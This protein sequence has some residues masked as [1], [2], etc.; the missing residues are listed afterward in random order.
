MAWSFNANTTPATGAEVM[1]DMKTRL[2][3]AGWVVKSSS[4]GTTY[5]STGDQISSPGSGANGMN[6]SNAWFRIQDP[7]TLREFLFQ[8]GTT[9]L[10]WKSYYSALDKFTGGAPSATVLPTA[11]DQQQI[12]GTGGAFNTAWFPTDATYRAHHGAEAAAISGV[13]AFYVILTLNGTGVVQKGSL[14]IE[15]GAAGSFP[16]AD[17]DPL[18]IIPATGSTEFLYTSLY[19]VSTSVVRGWYKM[20]LAGETWVMMPAKALVDSSYT[21]WPGGSGTNPYDSDDNGFPV[22]YGRPSG[23]ATQIGHKMVGHYYKWKSVNARN[24][25]DTA[26]LATANAMVYIND[27]MVPWP[28]STTPLT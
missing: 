3:A 11:T 10:S 2:V 9:S 18:I 22:V 19:N 25:P 14:I 28:T 27:L 6:N 12:I 21:L 4:D 26:G 13:Y 16:S 8:R 23:F 1:Y 24:Y 17:A 20:N 5:N 15:A 7:A